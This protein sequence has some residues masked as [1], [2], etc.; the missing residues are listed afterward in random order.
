MYGKHFAQMYTGSM[1]GIGSVVFAVWGYV[2]AHTREDHCVELNVKPLAGALGE[3]EENVQ[4][5]LDTLQAPDPDSRSKEYEGR[6]LV[7]HP[8]NPFLYF[9]PTHAAYRN[10]RNEEERRAYNREKQ[11]ERRARLKAEA[12]KAEGGAESAK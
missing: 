5:A 4:E 9:V 1:Y 3:T 2:I 10:T 12:E 8:E 11:R 7:P 6:R